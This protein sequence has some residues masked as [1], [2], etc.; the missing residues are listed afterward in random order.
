MKGEIWKEIS[1]FS[2]YEASNL[3]NLKNKTTKK[4]LKP[5]TNKAGYVCTSIINDKKET[6]AMKVH[7][8]IALTFIENPE[9]KKTVNHI[10]HNR[11]NNNITNL[12]WA[13]STE[14][15][16]HKRKSTK[17]VQHG[18]KVWRIENDTD[19][20]IEVYSSMLLAAKWVF[21]NKLTTV[22]EFKG[23]QSISSGICGVTRGKKSTAFGYKWKYD[24]EDENKYENEI[25]KKIPLDVS[26]N[27]KGYEASNYGRVKNPKGKINK[28][29]LNAGGYWMITI[30]P[31]DYL[32]HRIICQVFIKNPDNKEQVNHKDGNK[33]NAKVDNL[34]WMTNAENVQHSQDSGLN[35]SSKKVIQYDLNKNKI[36]EYISC[37]KASDDLNINYSGVCGCCSGRTK[38]AGGFIFEYTGQ[39]KIDKAPAKPKHVNTKKIVQYDLNMKKIKE[40]NSRLAASESLKIYSSSISACCNGKRK[41][42]G[43]FIFKDINENEVK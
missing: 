19:K 17:E 26:N 15:N 12:E 38:T 1:G 43:G 35:A 28:G 9:N 16:L 32:L 20:K 25:W 5:T 27:L 11:S 14:Q 22:T 13:T 42:A 31:K 41:T 29:Y 40:F 8:L 23:G 36:K 30:G 18:R 37:K 4:Q 6:K 7:R 24:D 21:D 34:E 2:N 10:D 39:N 3:G 33:Q